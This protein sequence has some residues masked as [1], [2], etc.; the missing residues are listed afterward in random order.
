MT[1]PAIYMMPERAII[2]EALNVKKQRKIGLPEI[3][4]AKLEYRLAMMVSLL[5]LICQF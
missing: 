4:Y 2:E 3:E 1:Y 5:V